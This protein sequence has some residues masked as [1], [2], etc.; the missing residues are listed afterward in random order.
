MS[1]PEA[2][3]WQD[4]GPVEAFPAGEVREATAGKGKVAISCKDGKFGVISGVCNHV[5]G[6]LGEGRLD[7]EYVVCPWHNWK[8]HRSTGQ[9]EPGFEQDCVPSYESKVEGGHLWVRVQAA[10][11]RH[12]AP[13]ERHPLA[14][15]VVR[16][17]GPIRVAGIS[18]TAMDAANP[19]YSTSDALLEYPLNTARPMAMRRASSG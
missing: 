12:K 10:T 9:G 18:T 5:G 3:A 2:Q 11:Q 6:P 15:P 1:S 13:H 8:F 19:R 7:S 14:R 16:E 4:L 17:S